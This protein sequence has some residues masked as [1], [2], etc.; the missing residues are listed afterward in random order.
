[1]SNHA[2]EVVGWLAALL[3]I[4]SEATG[5][6]IV[7]ARSAWTGSQRYP[8]HWGG[9]SSANWDS[10]MGEDL[11]GP[12]WIEVSAALDRMP[13]YVREGGIVPV[14]PVLQDVDERA[15]DEVTLRIAPFASSGSSSF[16]APV[17]GELIAVRYE[18]TD[19]DHRVTIA[20]SRVSVRVESLGYGAPRLR[21]A[22]TD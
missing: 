21:I 15:A 16:V 10:W 17:N 5:E 20:P 22:P 9:D 3:D 2:L 18:A 11:S 6:D 1:M 8:L 4:T 14:V 7:W 19:D 13:L 12:V